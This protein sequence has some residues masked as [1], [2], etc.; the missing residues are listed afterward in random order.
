MAAYDE[1]PQKPIYRR[2]KTPN[3]TEVLPKKIKHRKIHLDDELSLD[4]FNK[5]TDRTLIRGDLPG[6]GK[7]T[8]PIL[9]AI[10]NKKKILV[11][12]PTNA[13]AHDVLNKYSSSSS[14]M[15]GEVDCI[16]FA[17]LVGTIMIS[18]TLGKLE[19]S[20][21][22]EYDVSGY[23]I[24]L[25]DEIYSLTTNDLYKLKNFMERNGGK[26]IMFLAAGDPLQN[27]PIE[28]EILDGNI[29]NEAIK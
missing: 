27:A 19:E 20:Q 17:S 12:V 9:W 18:Q 7:T 29:Y 5:L 2:D 26:K 23:D 28:G 16:T 11:V 4:S 25:I 21:K 24:V 10:K 6:S 3:P 14:T 22:K 8:N 1:L 13:L 15:G